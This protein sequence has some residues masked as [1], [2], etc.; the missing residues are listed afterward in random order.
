MTSVR[1]SIRC[2]SSAASSTDLVIAH[3]AL[4]AG[5]GLLEPA[6]AAAAGMDLRL[7][8]PDRPVQFA[9]RGLGLV[10]LQNDP[11]VRHG[12]AV[13]PQELLGLIFMDVH[14]PPSLAGC[15][16]RWPPAVRTAAWLGRRGRVRNGI[17]T[18]FRFPG[19]KTAVCDHR[20]KLSDHKIENRRPQPG[21]SRFGRGRSTGRNP[22]PGAQPSEGSIAL[23]A[24]TRPWTASID[25]SNIARSA[26]LSVISTIR[27]MPPAPI[28][29]GTP[30]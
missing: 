2:A 24:S 7:D 23:Q 20:E 4:L 18:E 30:T 21:T 12:R 29:V 17:A 28:T 6:L 16:C 27:S 25:L 8:H 14:L 3:A 15:R 1:P 19:R 9:C 13:L 11:S 5:G 10:G 26:R 22:V